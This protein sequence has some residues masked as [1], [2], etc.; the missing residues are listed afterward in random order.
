VVRA[1]GRR[2]AEGGRFAGD[3]H[4]MARQELF[5]WWWMRGVD[6]AWSLLIPLASAV[7]LWYGGGQVLADAERVRAGAL[8]PEDAFTTGDLVMFLSYLTALLG[9]SRAGRERD[10]AAEPAAGFDRP[11][12]CWPSGEMPSARR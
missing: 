7:L 10:R 6:I 11:L 1:F 8:R 4:Y 12:D 5:A 9:R 2:R 3:N